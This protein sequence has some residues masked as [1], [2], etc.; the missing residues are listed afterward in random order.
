MTLS[1]VENPELQM[2]PELTSEFSKVTGYEAK[3]YTFYFCVL[4]MED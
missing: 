3:I 2:L 1:S 4:T